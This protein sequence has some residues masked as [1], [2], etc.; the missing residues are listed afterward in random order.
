MESIIK[1]IKTV[2]FPK[3][4]KQTKNEIQTQNIKYIHYV[5]IAVGI[6][7]FISVLVFFFANL[8]RLSE[9]SVTDAMIRVSLSVLLCLYS[10]N[11]SGII[12]RKNG[13]VANHP[14]FTGFFVYS[15]IIL[16]IAWSMFVSADNY[17]H[18]GQLLTFYT[19]ELI[20]AL[21]VKLSPLFTT[22]VILGSYA[23][24]Y[25]TL[26]LFFTGGNINIYNY[27]MLALLTVT[28]ALLNYYLTVKYIDEKNKSNFLNDALEIIANHDSLTRLQN[29]YALNQKI[30][31]Y[32]DEEICVILGDINQFK[33]VND[34]Y[35]HRVGDD[36]LALFS[37]TLREFFKDENI[38]RYGGDE[39]LIVEK[40]GDLEEM[41]EKCRRVNEK[42][43]AAE[44]EMLNV[45]FGWCYGY[46][47]GKPKTAFEFFSLIEQSDKLLYQ[48]KESFKKTAEF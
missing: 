43:S 12:L 16:L 45:E 30:A 27:A 2:F 34:T 18:G 5:S 22:I 38:Y 44:S 21:F 31:D 28:G 9:S 13:A 24:N 46:V 26:I 17:T 19:V 14:R 39:F 29:R 42:F 20:A 48:E 35:G 6:I 37:K 11:V 3:I 33:T 4:N 10:F 1:K 25:F 47:S 40:A 36:I 7:Q 23:L 15:F 8:N 41:I 32:L